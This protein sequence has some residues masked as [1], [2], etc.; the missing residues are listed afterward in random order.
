MYFL[1]I[2]TLKKKR[3]STDM[4]LETRGVL[5]YRKASLTK[6][7]L[8][9]NTFSALERMNKTYSSPDGHMVVKRLLPIGFIEAIV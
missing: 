7:I 6:F 9:V 3:F 4:L 1:T 5:T 8:K 2:E